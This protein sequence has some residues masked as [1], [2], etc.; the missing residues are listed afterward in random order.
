MGAPHARKV[1]TTREGCD[2][3]VAMKKRLRKKLRVGE[4]QE[5]GFP[6][7]FRIS[8]ELSEEQ[9]GEFLGD[10]LTSAVEA[11]GLQFGGG[12]DARDWEGFI[13]LY[14]RGSV[15]EDHRRAID[16]WLSEDPRVLHH[17]VG[18][19]TDAWWGQADSWPSV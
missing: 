5:L 7:R 1:F 11:R 3:V 19:L 6:V 16:Q 17:E 12:G 18:P 2:E 10:W 9:L 14:R 15:T 8:E 13:E 4:F